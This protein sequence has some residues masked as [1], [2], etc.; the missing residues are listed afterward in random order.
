MVVSSEVDLPIFPFSPSSLKRHFSI[1]SKNLFY[2]TFFI[3]F[4]R[5]VKSDCDILK[6]FFSVYCNLIEILNF[7]GEDEEWSDS[8]KTPSVSSGVEGG[9]SA[10]SSPSAPAVEEESSLPPPPRLNSVLPV[11]TPNS[12]AE[13]IRLRFSVLSEDARK[14]LSSLTEDIEVSFIFLFIQKFQM[15]ILKID[16]KTLNFSTLRQLDYEI[17]NTD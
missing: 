13:D 11:I 9:G 10:V 3:F 12:V 8:E 17:N 2:S 14:R 4:L 7:P 5:S 16:S 1:K 15:L 6:F